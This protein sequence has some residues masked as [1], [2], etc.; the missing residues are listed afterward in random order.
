MET[1]K[2][3]Y[4]DFWEGFS[5]EDFLCTQVL[6]QKHDVEILAD[7]KDADYV[8]F[9]V[10]GDEHWFLSPDKIKI[11]YTGENICP[12]FNACD[13]AVGFEWFVF[14]D[15]YLRMPNY[16]ATRFHREQTALFEKRYEDAES[17]RLQYNWAVNR[18]FCSFVVSNGDGNPIRRQLFEAIS[19]YKPVD[20]GGRWMN[21]VGGPVED[22][23]A[24]ESDHKFSIACENSSHP[25]YTTEKI[26]EAFAARTIPIYWGDPEICKVFNPKAFIN[27]MDYPSIDAVVQR[28]KELDENEEAYIDMLK[29]SAMQNPVEYSI[30]NQMNLMADFMQ[31]IVE[32]PLNKAQRY[33]REFWGQRYRDRERSL[34]I[35]SRKNWKDLLKERFC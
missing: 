28:V 20:S 14:G 17:N 16:Y 4:V 10:F 1:I 31:H 34:I 30:E 15:R 23:I 27:V 11:F 6:R 13:Y 24:F 32:Q 29:E 5:P 33:N 7:P 18:K 12:D 8:F 35:R 19:R 3:A 2:I 21:N 26:V 22:K 9:S 25:G